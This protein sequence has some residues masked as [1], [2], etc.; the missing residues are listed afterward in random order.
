MP[1]ELSQP[2]VE[3]KRYRRADL[4]LPEIRMPGIQNVVELPIDHEAGYL[5]HGRAC[6]HHPPSTE[7]TRRRWS[8]Q[9]A[10]ILGS[11]LR[12]LD[13]LLIDT[14]RNHHPLHGRV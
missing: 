9:L 1:R 13:E 5:Q 3:G 8:G 11:M 10:P 4:Q 6:L 7:L 14:H 12:V 2:R